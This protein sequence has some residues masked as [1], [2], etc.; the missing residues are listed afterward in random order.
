MV[1]TT[2]LALGMTSTPNPVAAGGMLSYELTFGNPTVTSV[3]GVTLAVP[4]PTGTSFVSATGGGTLVGGVVQWNVGTLGPGVAGQRQ[5]T[6]QVNSQVVSGSLVESTAGADGVG[7]AAQVWR[8]PM[9]CD[10][11]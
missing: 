9:R 10:G 4:L 2:D 8:E 7:D 5:L 3:S 6:V 11:A 1:S